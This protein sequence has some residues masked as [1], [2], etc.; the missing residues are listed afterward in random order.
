MT[1]LNAHTAVEKT[2][3]V[4]SSSADHVV[5]VLL[6]CHFYITSSSVYCNYTVVLLHHF[7]E[8]PV[9]NMF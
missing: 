7:I 6:N 1:D 4:A 5:T 3:T 2:Y 8:S 9:N